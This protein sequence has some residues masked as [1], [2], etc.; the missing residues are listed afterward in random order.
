MSWRRWRSGTFLKVIGIC[1]ALAGVLVGCDRAPAPPPEAKTPS[2]P[3]VT[4][5]GDEPRPT[6]QALLLGPRKKLLLPNM[7]LALRVPESWKTEPA[8][9]LIVLTGPTPADQVTIQLAVRDPLPA[10]RLTAYIE[11]LKKEGDQ[12]AKPPELRQVGKMQVL[13]RLSVSKPITIARKDARNEPVVDD[14]GNPVTDTFTPMTWRVSV[15]VPESQAVF[16][17]Y[18]LNCINFIQEQ[19]AADHGLI[20]EVFNS[21]VYDEAGTA[22]QAP[23]ADPSAAKPQ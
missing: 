4:L 1:L 17:R 5:P 12:P 20:E 10:D 19:Y 14:K 3:P 9:P 7:P 13:E 11:R 2:P 8:G 21:L 22:T 18:E 16:S 6:T 15:F 23:A